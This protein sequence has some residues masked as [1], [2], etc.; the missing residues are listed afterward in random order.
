MVHNTQKVNVSKVSF[1]TFHNN[2][3]P[4]V[5]LHSIGK[6]VEKGGLSNTVIGIYP[7]ITSRRAFWQYLTK[8]ICPL[9]K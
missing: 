5:S 9:T 4:N 2:K 8:Y 6:A 7:G 1:F 3:D